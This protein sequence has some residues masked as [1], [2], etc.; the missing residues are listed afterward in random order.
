MWLISKLCTS[1][2]QRVWRK[3]ICHGSLDKTSRSDHRRHIE[4]IAPSAHL[5][6]CR[7]LPL[8]AHTKWSELGQTNIWPG[9]IFSYYRPP[10]IRAQWNTAEC[11]EEWRSLRGMEVEWVY[12]LVVGLRHSIAH[13]WFSIWRRV[14]VDGNRKWNWD[15]LRRGP[16]RVAAVMVWIQEST[17][18]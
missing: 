2:M 10:F 5:N 1:S 11:P 3:V 12:R 16:Q 15:V 7:T 13:E 14:T 9:L 17:F 4:V 6:Q 8:W 18:W